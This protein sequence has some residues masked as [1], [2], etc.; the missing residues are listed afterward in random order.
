MFVARFVPMA[1]LP[2][3][4]LA[5]SLDRFAIAPSGGTDARVGIDG[6]ACEPGTFDANGDPSDGCECTP[7]APMT[8]LCD[9][10]DNDCDESTPDGSE[11]PGIGP[12]CDGTDDDLC[13]EGSW[14]CIGGRAVCEDA[15]DNS[16]EMCNEADDDC[17]GM[18]DET[19]G[20]EYY[21][22]ADSDGYG[23]DSDVVISCTPL[24]GREPRG[25]DCDDYD[26]QVNPGRP[27]TC[28]NFQD[29]DCDGVLDNGCECVSVVEGGRLYSF[30]SGDLD[31]R[32]ARDRCTSRG[33][34]LASLETD[35]EDAFVVGQVRARGLAPAWVGLHDIGDEGNWRWV[36]ET[37]IART[38]WGPGEP[39]NGP[40]CCLN[41]ENCGVVAWH[42][43]PDT[44]NDDQCSNTHAYVCESGAP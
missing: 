34:A 41:D 22:D 5:C 20:T 42:P 24:D 4:L 14:A 31:W 39:N 33:Q 1:L 11:D 2:L 29:D 32:D 16:R 8:E 7:T 18:V 13:E 9:G 25:G 35:E 3:L 19:V 26:D 15:T 30:C 28:G 27:E 38:A 23:T 36:D 21:A 6:A 44:W 40:G 10:F 37:P 17:D 12:P 43:D